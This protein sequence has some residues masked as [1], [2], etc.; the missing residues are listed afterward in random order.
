MDYRYVDLFLGI[1]RF[2]V[3]AVF[4]LW[5]F[6]LTLAFY[7]ER[8]RK[9]YLRNLERVKKISSGMC[10]VENPDKGISRVKVTALKSKNKWKRIEALLVLGYA[11]CSA[12][13]NV[14]REALFCADEDVAYFSMLSLGQVKTRQ[15]AVI[16][17]DFLSA[18]VF[19]GYRIISLLEEFPAE[20]APDVRRAAESEDA[21]SR[22]WAIKLLSRFPD[23]GTLSLLGKLAQDSS[24]DVR[25]AVCECLGVWGYA[26]TRETLVKALKDEA[27]FVRMHAVRSLYKIAGYECLPDIA[28]LI[29]DKS[30]LVKESVETIM[31]RH[32]DEVLPIISECLADYDDNSKFACVNAL[33]NS[34]HIAQVLQDTLSLFPSQKEHAMELLGNLIKTK[35]YF[36]LKKNLGFF[37]PESRDKLLS[38]IAEF[39]NELAGRLRER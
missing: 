6:I 33:V 37:S 29:R 4:F 34:H 19:S 25:A 12:P 2:V 23:R 39:D 31:S 1:N 32:I 30:W 18:H 10:L 14:L 3:L 13:E 11:E 35:F 17:L 7:K 9:T 16:L 28:P 20:I 38:I 8:S 15:A 36:G 27:W 24:A 5:I 21:L 26:E 22:F